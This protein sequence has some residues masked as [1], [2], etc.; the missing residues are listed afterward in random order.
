MKHAPRVESILAVMVMVCLFAA[1]TYQKNAG[2]TQNQIQA[3][4]IVQMNRS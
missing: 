3:H 2:G 1:L 4:I